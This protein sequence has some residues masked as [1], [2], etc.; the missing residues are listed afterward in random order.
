MANLADLVL[1]E[2]RAYLQIRAAIGN[3]AEALWAEF[4]GLGD[5]QLA[6]WLEQ[7]VPTVQGAQLAAGNLMA[8][9][10]R[11]FLETASGRPF[12]PAGLNIENLI[13]EARNGTTALDVYTRPVIEARTLVSRGVPLGDALKRAGQRV[14]TTAQTDVALTHRDTAHAVL[15]NEPDVKGF[16]RV[17]TGRSCLFCAA[18]S[19][20]RYWIGDLMPL[21]A[22]CDCTVAP[23]W[24]KQDPGRIINRDRYQALR[25]LGDQYWNR[26]GYIDEEGNVFTV[27]D[28]ETTPAPFQVAVEE[29]GELGPVLV[30]PD[31]HFTGPDEVG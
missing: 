27:K 4:G 9:Y 15:S 31:H 1:A 10:L 21:H 5:V 23:I 18:A 29:H 6:S 22:N 3:Q 30:D 16:E 2:Q 13:A 24:G 28:G 7:I 20:Q 14:A 12:D 11:T 25:S 8:G 26:G 17:L 19:T